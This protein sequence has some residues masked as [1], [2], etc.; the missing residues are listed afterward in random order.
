MLLASASYNYII[1]FAVV[2]IISYFFDL[3]AKKSGVPAVLMLIGLGIVINIGLNAND[4]PK[5][6]YI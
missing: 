5:P 2:I 6:E 3:Y 1:L 4:I